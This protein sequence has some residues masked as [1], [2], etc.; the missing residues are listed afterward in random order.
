MSQ[1]GKIR[2]ANHRNAIVALKR[3]NNRGLSAYHCSRCGGWHLGNHPKKKMQRILQILDQV[4]G[5]AGTPAP[6]GE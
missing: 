4:M 5:R 6:K 3:L 1:C 2:H